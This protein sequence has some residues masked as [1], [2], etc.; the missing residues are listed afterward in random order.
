MD[1]VAVANRTNQ[2]VLRATLPRLFSG[3]VAHRSGNVIIDAPCLV[4]WI[5]FSLDNTACQDARPLIDIDVL[6]QS[7]RAGEELRSL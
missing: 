7:E 3:I 1:I 2:G 5:C 4:Q 6:L